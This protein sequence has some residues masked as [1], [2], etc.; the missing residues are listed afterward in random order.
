MAERPVV[1]ALLGSSNLTVALP[2]ALRHLQSHFPNRPLT[3]LVAYGPGRSY[4]IDGG[5]LGI[6][7]TS[8]SRCELFAAFEQAHEQDASSDAYALLTDIGND[9][10][11]GV[12]APVLVGRV[13]SIVERFRGVGTRVAV[14]AL[15]AEAI[16]AL[17]PPM[18][19]FARTLIYPG[20]RATHDE[21]VSSVRA[22]QDEL[23][24]MASRGEI[25]LLPARHKWYSPDA[26]HIRPSRGGEA[27]GEWLDALVGV[28]DAMG[29]GS[30]PVAHLTTEGLYLQCRPALRF[31]G[32]SSRPHDARPFVAAP[33]VTVRGF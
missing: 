11:H 18:F 7:F 28:D 15:P 20:N 3:I 19:H 14:T 27:F 5:S 30:Q 29:R 16:A 12:S 1:V 4:E 8:L 2:A 10:M 32:R 17:S 26:C 22:V 33:G 23:H 21:V 13:R 9:L 24:E 31:F 6:K 25:K